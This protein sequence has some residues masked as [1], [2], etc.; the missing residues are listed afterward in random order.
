MEWR[1]HPW[2]SHSHVRWGVYLADDL[3]NQGFPLRQEDRVVRDP[4]LESC[5]QRE[6]GRQRKWNQ[7]RY[8]KDPR[9][10]ENGADHPAVL[11]GGSGLCSRGKQI[12]FGGLG[13]GFNGSYD[14]HSVCGGAGEGLA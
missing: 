5:T 1:D 4:S 2:S 8:F 14:S 12:G 3:L 9:G 13:D 6:R 11:S 10:I 7:Q